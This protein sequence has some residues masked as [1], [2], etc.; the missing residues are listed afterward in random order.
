MTPEREAKA[1]R[2]LELRKQ[3]LDNEAI[4]SRLGLSRNYIAQL[5]KDLSRLDG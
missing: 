4:A 3:G 5:L 2:A 1:R